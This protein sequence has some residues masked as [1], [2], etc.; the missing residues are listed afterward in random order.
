MRQGASAPVS[1]KMPAPMQAPM[2]FPIVGPPSLLGVPFLAGPHN[3]YCSLLEY[4]L[5]PLIA[6]M[7]GA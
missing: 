5:G 1:T 6:L 3:K 7:P 2:P 4:I